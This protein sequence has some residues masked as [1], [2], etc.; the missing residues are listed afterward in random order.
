MTIEFWFGEPPEN[1]PQALA[2][3]FM[4][5]YPGIKVN[6][7]RYVNDD[8]GNTKLDTALQGGTPID[9][10]MSY[11]IP[12][13][14]QRIRAGVA[15][16]LTSYIAGDP[17]VKAWTETT[18][19]LFKYQG[20]FFSLP[21]VRD[22][23]AVI[24]NK[25]L[26]EAAGGKLP[27]QWTIDDFHTLAKQVSSKDVFG[28][29]SPPDLARQIIGPDYWYKNGG[30]ESNFDNPAFKQYLDL[31]TGMIKEKSAF[32]WTEVL[33]QN[34]RVYQQNVYLT[35]QAVLWPGSMYVLR[36]VN[37][38]KQYPHDF[39]T[40]FAPMPTPTGSGKFYNPGSISNDVIL[41]PKAK[42]KE[43]AWAF[44]RFRLTDGAKYMLKSGK[45]P[46]FPGASPDE[47]IDGILGPDKDTLYDVEAFKKA[48]LE[49]AFNLV[50]D[51]ITVASAEIQK[52]VQ[53]QTDRCLIGEISVDQWV[54]TVKQQADAAIAKAG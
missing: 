53:D 9:V 36:Y 2:D 45:V 7:T 13:L 10:Y 3:A 41:N 23:Y 54:Q 38:K 44:F 25:K 28:C 17:A 47:V 18:D 46:A 6:T 35:S 51:T 48:Y 39:V 31:Y 37:D 24:I 49:P 15:E 34:L 21:T 32:P 11:G 16:E 42:N 27:T 29:Y 1:G 40:T 30:K 19:G 22:P 43:A 50:T 52:I 14:G 26:L 33:A 5:Q 20:K 12:R 8:T 4:K